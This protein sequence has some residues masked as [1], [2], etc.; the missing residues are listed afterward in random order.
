MK[1]VI[2]QLTTLISKE[3]NKA[4]PNPVTWKPDMT[5]DTIIN[6]TAFITNVNIPRVKMLIGKVITNNMGRKKA[7]SM[8]NIPDANT[9]EKNPLT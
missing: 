7:L 2:S 8:P 9:A 5:P 6:S 3:P 1:E 4:D